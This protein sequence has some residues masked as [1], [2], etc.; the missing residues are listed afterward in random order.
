MKHHSKGKPRPGIDPVRVFPYYKL[1]YFDER[2][3]AWMD[4]QI[5]F[6]S[7]DEAVSHAQSKFEGTT[8][9]R[10]MT[11]EGEKRRRIFENCERVGDCRPGMG[12]NSGAGT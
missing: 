12:Q 11:V 1:Q 7:R 8:R 2:V 5:R 9:I 3:V 10:I 4:V 6:E